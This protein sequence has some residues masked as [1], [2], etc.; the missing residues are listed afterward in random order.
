MT[1]LSIF[2]YSLFILLSGM[3]AGY[4]ISEQYYKQTTYWQELEKFLDV[5]NRKWFTKNQQYPD[6]KIK[7][8]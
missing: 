5:Y 2:C 7:Q 1:F 3:W 6:H 4:Q 8:H